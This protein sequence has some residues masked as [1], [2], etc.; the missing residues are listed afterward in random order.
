MKVLCLS[1]LMILISA[2]SLESVKP[3]DNR[4]SINYKAPESKCVFV[5]N[6][7][8]TKKIYKIN[9]EQELDNSIVTELVS[10]ATKNN[11]NYVE[12]VK[13]DDFLIKKASRT[14]SSTDE[15]SK[16]IFQNKDYYRVKIESNL[17][18]CSH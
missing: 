8:T 7:S 14:I 3:Q 18:S 2:C 16:S 4:V 13:Q 10:N 15:A 12:I 5:S 9:D 17:Y 1:V 11:A 6:H